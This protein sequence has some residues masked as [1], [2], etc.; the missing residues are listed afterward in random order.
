MLR[1][2]VGLDVTAFFLMV[3]VR[4]CDLLVAWQDEGVMEEFLHLDE[5]LRI[6]VKE[7]QLI[8][9]ERRLLGV[10]QSKTMVSKL[11]KATSEVLS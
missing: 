1:G 2:C 3:M 9:I 10:L 4:V 8:N 5:I 7:Q 6:V 11:L